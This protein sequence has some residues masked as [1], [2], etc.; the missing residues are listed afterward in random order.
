MATETRR[1]GVFP[2]W[3]EKT[4]GI[5]A[6]GVVYAIN[7][8]IVMLVSYKWVEYLMPPVVT[9]AIVAVIGLNLAPVAVGEASI[10]PWIAI[11][12]V[13]AVGAVAVFAPGLV[14]RLPILLG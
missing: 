7:A 11:V 2:R 9:G 1:E 5:I 14:R 13:L 6:A 10:N 12:T 3:T 8:V 4:E